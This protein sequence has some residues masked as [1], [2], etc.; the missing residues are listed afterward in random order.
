MPELSARP[1]LEQ[2]KKQ[3]KDLLHEHSLGTPAALVRIAHYHPRLLKLPAPEIRSTPI[4]LADAQLVLAREH[5]FESWAKFAAH[6][7]TINILHS[8]AALADPVATFIEAACIPRHSGH[9]TGDLEHAQIILSRYPQVATANIHTAAILADESTVRAILSRDPASATAKGGPHGWDALTHL[10]FSRYL[11]LDPT[12]SEAFVRI[13]E[14]LLDAGTS[15]NTGWYETN[16]NPSRSPEFE[17]AIYGAAAIARHSALTRLLL[18]RGADPND[19]ETPYHVP[20]SYDNTIT[21]LLLESGKLNPDSIATMLLRKCDWHDDVGLQLILSHGADPNAT[22]IWGHTALHQSLR[23]DNGLIMIEMLLNHE[24]NPTLPNREG[25]SSIQIA[26]H[27][28]RADALRLFAQRNFE[29]NL[30]GVDQ[31]VAACAL[32]DRESIRTLTT[33]HP[34][35]L[36]ELLEKGRTLLSEFAGNGN[37]EGLHALLDL[38]V[39]PAALYPGDGYFDIAPNSTALHVAAWRARPA[40]VKAL[41]A[42]GSPINALDAKGRTPLVLAI[43]AATDSYW[44]ARRTPE[45]IADLLSAGATTTGIQIPTGYD[46]ADQLLTKVSP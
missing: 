20:E 2:Y 42:R 3:A 43:K 31:L 39:S 46:K 30:Q 41:I 8:V 4:T 19:G 14:A 23:R 18:S 35:L 11:R 27:R 40:A 38:G 29:P 24:A 16:N 10:C 22:T 33:Q 1:N 45:S 5:G 17:S 25:L 28:G 7:R 26:A 44:Q 37:V 32:A 6:I 13:A 15:P 9:A 36:T 21:R 12:R 34:N